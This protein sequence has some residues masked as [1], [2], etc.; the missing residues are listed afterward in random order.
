MNFLK[1]KL[2]KISARQHAF[3]YFEVQLAVYLISIFG[4]LDLIYRPNTL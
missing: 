1:V 4:T 2:E 3:M